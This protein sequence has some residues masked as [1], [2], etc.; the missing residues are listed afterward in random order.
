MCTKEEDILHPQEAYLY[1]IR[2]LAKAITIN[3][4]INPQS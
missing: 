1:F 4:K 3:S 2:G